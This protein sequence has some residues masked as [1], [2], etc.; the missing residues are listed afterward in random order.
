MFST[1][2]FNYGSI[3]SSPYASGCTP[4]AEGK[5]YGYRDFYTAKD[6][7]QPEDE[8]SPNCKIVKLRV[9]LQKLISYAS[10]CAPKAVGQKIKIAMGKLVRPE[11]AVGVQPPAHRTVSEQMEN[12]RFPGFCVL[13]LRPG[14]SV[15]FNRPWFFVPFYE[16]SA[17]SR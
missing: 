17:F 3:A 1:S 14:F 15:P 10:G 8:F 6:M 4:N 2:K 12:T 16:N 7:L 5:G 13:F 11:P 9:G